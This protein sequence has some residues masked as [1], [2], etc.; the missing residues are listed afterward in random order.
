MPKKTNGWNSKIG[1]LSDVFAFSKEYF[2]DMFMFQVSFK[3]CDSV[4]THRIHVWNIYLHLVDLY[5]VGKYTSPMDPS[6]EMMTPSVG[7]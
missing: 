3:G 6:W 4:Q 1:G 2:Q 5:G 7:V